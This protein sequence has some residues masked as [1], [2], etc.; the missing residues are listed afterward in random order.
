[1]DPTETLRCTP[2]RQLLFS[3]AVATT[4]IG[5]SDASSDEPMEPD[6]GDPR[7]VELAERAARPPLEGSV[8][9]DVETEPILLADGNAIWVHPTDPSLS[10][11]IGADPLTGLSVFRLD[12]ALI[13]SLPFT[14]AGGGEVDVRY[15]FPLGGEEVSIVAGGQSGRNL[16]Y[17]YRVDANTGMLVDVMA[18]EIDSTNDVYGSC[19]YRSATS[20][21]FYLFVTS[22]LGNIVQ[23]ELMDDGTGAVTAERVRSF[24][25]DPSPGTSPTVEA[26]VAD[27]E[28]GWLYLAQE[29][30]RLIWRYRAE[31]DGG[32]ERALVDD[33]GDNPDDNI[34]G[35][36]IY[37]VGPRTGYVIASVQGSWKYRVYTREVDAIDDKN[38]F[39][40]SFDIA[41]GAAADGATAH[42]CIEVTNVNLGPPF[43]GGMLV[44]QDITNTL[45]GSEGGTNY[46]LVD[47]T[48]VATALDLVVDTSWDPRR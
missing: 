31:P 32:D 4:A 24:Q 30:D 17:A 43:S 33:V 45:P 36:A 16:L 28:G 48:K 29:N 39:L 10:T 6:A 20:G 14:D 22:R 42:D 1:M 19:L 27:D 9:A 12:G 40:G 5:C 38:F 23:F 21:K 11:V 8:A 18:G 37:H 3:L 44:T 41:D 25:I 46:K 35:L 13:Q 26:C 47:W 15:G 34:E 7:A 2:F